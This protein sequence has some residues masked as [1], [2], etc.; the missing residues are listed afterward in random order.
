MNEHP[1]G[2]MKMIFI[3]IDTA[4][5]FLPFG[6]VKSSKQAVWDRFI[7]KILKNIKKSRKIEIFQNFYIDPGGPG[8]H[9]RGSRTDSGGEKHQNS[10]KNNFFVIFFSNIKIPKKI[11]IRDTK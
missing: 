10:E 7:S 9:P 5:N 11:I 3:P 4:F 8:G 6:M 1:I 2:A